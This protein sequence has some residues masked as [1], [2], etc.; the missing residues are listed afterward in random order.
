VDAD[1]RVKVG[2]FA[3]V[4]LVVKEEA[5]V[6]TIPKLALT[7]YYEDQMVYVIKDNTAERR[8]VSV[9]LSSSDTV[10]ITEGLEEGETIIVRGLSSISDG[11]L[12]S[13][14]E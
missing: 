11:T 13:I 12:V 10:Q 4:K 7:T 9:G 3:S 6:I 8:T 5:N 2:M 1:S 14:V